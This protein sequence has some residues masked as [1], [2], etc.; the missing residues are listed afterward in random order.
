VKSIA[1]VPAVAVALA[2]ASPAAS[3]EPFGGTYQTTVTGITGQAAPLNGAWVLTFAANGGYAV[4]K[5]PSAARLITG[6]ATVTGKT[7]AFRDAGGPLACRGS[8]SLGTYTWARSRNK[9]TL[10]IVRD[11]CPG[12]PLILA[13]RTFTKIS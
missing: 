7:I 3:K 10:R 1:L 9:L 13:G 11:A 6:K 4:T 2:V 8:A 12:R 5:K